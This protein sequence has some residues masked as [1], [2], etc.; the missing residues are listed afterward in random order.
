MYL[1]GGAI[2]ATGAGYFALNRN[3][4]YL[5]VFDA[6]HIS[7]RMQRVKKCIIPHYLFLYNVILL[8]R[9]QH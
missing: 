5:H 9:I 3:K 4:V 8:E 2:I 7:N 6:R 1:V